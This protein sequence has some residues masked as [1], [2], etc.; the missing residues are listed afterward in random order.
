MHCRSIISELYVHDIDADVKHT[1]SKMIAE[2]ESVSVDN[3]LFQ[4]FSGWPAPVFNAFYLAEC[5]EQGIPSA[6]AHERL[7]RILN[8]IAKSL[9]NEQPIA[10]SVGTDPQTTMKDLSAMPKPS[11]KQL[12]DHDTSVAAPAA[13][14]PSV[15][16]SAADGQH[17]AVS[18]TFVPGFDPSTSFGSSWLNTDKPSQ[19]TQPPSANGF[20]RTLSLFLAAT[21]NEL[22]DSDDEEDERPGIGIAHDARGAVVAGRSAARP[23]FGPV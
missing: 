11:L 21:M 16:P 10:I 14:E 17:I 1:V 15:T 7:G 5:T 12:A 20:H 8:I 23:R 3:A 22:D 19:S 9:T 6:Q 4:P 13:I 2:A 18:T